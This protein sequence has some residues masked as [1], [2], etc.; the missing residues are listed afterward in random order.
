MELQKRTIVRIGL[1]RICAYI[2]TSVV[3]YFAT[4]NITQAISFGLI[5]HSIKFVCQYVYERLWNKIK[6]GIYMKQNE[7]KNTPDQDNV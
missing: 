5:D 2:G 7:N 3:I 4:K 6:W 1:W